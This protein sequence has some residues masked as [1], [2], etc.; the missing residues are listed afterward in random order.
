MNFTNTSPIIDNDQ[1]QSFVDHFW[2]FVFDTPPGINCY[3]S[4]DYL[5]IEKLHEELEAKML[6]LCSEISEIFSRVD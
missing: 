2:V 4:P 3:L 1:W 6:I 5:F